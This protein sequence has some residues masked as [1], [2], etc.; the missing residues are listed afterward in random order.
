MAGET[1]ETLKRQLEYERAQRRG[2]DIAEAWLWRKAKEEGFQRTERNA[3]ALG[4]W[5][6]QHQL[7]ISEANLDK[8]YSILKKAGH[9]FTSPLEEGQV[10]E[11]PSIPAH[12][13]QFTTKRELDK[14]SSD[15]YI[16]AQKGPHG[17]A[18]KARVNEVLR[19][20]A[21]GESQ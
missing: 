2:A 20:H 18:W 4:L 21:A 14:M 7:P 5:L 3:Q 17:A 1:V 11:L 16:K 6:T 12:L 15:V 10:A 19:R 13:P 8:A 9:D